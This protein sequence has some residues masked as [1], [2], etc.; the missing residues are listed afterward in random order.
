MMQK[1]TILQPELFDNDN[2]R[3]I[4]KAYT[5]DSAST[6]EK[7]SITFAGDTTGALDNDNANSL[8]LA[9]WLGG[10]STWTSGTLNTSW[11]S[12]TNSNRAVGVVNLAD[13]TSNE[14]YITGIQLEVL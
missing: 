1:I 14:W 2:S 7:K 3:Q 12:N 6:W 13:S 9:L 5:V 4:S 10:G 8:Q 11:N